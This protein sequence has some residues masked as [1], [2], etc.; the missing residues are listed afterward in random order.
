[1]SFMTPAVV[2]GILI[3]IATAVKVDWDAFRGFKS[4]HDAA[5]YNWSLTLWRALQGALVG[6][7]GATGIGAYLG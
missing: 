3:G 2:S 1:M 5:E 7:F 6:F 4:F